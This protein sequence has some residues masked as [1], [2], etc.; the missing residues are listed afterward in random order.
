LVKAQPPAL[1]AAE[2]AA[3][4]DEAIAV[5]GQFDPGEFNWVG[6]YRQGKP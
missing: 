5:T 4:H 6:H 1:S 2:A 3:L